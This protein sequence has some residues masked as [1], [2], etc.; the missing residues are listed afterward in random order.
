M[1]IQFGHGH[2]NHT[3]SA[4]TAFVYPER[5]R[6]QSVRDPFVEGAL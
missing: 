6:W 3:R 5:Y 4:M 2:S 1:Y